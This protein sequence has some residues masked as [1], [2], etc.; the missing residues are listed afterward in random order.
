MVVRL[1]ALYT[2]RLY[3]Q[4]MLLVLI[5]GRG[6]VDPRA[7][8]RSEGL[9]QWKIPMTPSGIESSTFRFIAQYL[10]HCA[11]ISGPL[12]GIKELW[13]LR[14]SIRWKPYPI[15][16]VSKFLPPLSVFL[17]NL[18]EIRCKIATHNA[19]ERWKISWRS[20]EGRLY[21]R[22]GH[23]WTLQVRV[24]TETVC[25]LY[26]QAKQHDDY[27]CILR[28]RLHCLVKVK[29]SLNK[30]RT[31]RRGMECRAQTGRQTKL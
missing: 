23:N 8:G 13:L 9:C 15:L 5:S 26:F 19:T 14:K 22:Y 7:I 3:P 16:G 2:G 31:R 29:V 27:V 6:L 25:Y 18:T 17:S 10:N 11:T 30:L 12:I 4:E 28:H 24:L 1:S 21:F 20:A